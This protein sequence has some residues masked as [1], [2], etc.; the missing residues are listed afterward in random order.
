MLSQCFI[1]ISSENTLTHYSP[2][3]LFYTLWKQKTFRFS[4]VFS[5]YRKAAPGCNGLKQESFLIILWKYRNGTLT[6]DGLIFIFVFSYSNKKSCYL[7]FILLNPGNSW[8]G[9]FKFFKIKSIFPLVS[10]PY[11]YLMLKL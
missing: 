7:L 10:T 8:H 11:T 1:C 2:V 6:Q 4:D 3:L 5:G 9:V